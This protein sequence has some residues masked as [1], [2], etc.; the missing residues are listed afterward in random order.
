MDL[1]VI[2]LKACSRLENSTTFLVKVKSRNICYPPFTDNALV[3]FF[4][5]VEND[6][7]CGADMVMRM[8][9]NHMFLLHMDV[10]R[11]QRTLGLMEIIIFCH[12]ETHSRVACDGGL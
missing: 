11:V 12:K 2:C 6:G 9:K 3:G 10:V 8:D 5:G 4:N 1:R 7:N